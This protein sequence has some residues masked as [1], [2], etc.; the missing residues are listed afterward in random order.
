M[1]EALDA[2]LGA[3][4]EAEVVEGRAGHPVLPGVVLHPSDLAGIHLTLEH[5]TPEL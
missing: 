1:G 4:A 5:S 2:S 3:G